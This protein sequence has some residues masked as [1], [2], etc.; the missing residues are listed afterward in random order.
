MRLLDTK[1]LRLKEF[2]GNR[3]PQ[4]AILSHTWGDE[5]VLFQ[6][7]K[8][9]LSLT[10]IWK[11]GSKKVRASCRRAALD[12]YKYIWIDTC[13]I[14]KS[15]SAEISES[16]NSMF[17]W[18]QSASVCY[19][20]LEDVQSLERLTDSR[21]FTRGWTLQ[22]LIAPCD[23]RFYN[24]NWELLGDRYRL[25][26]SQVRVTGIDM[27]ILTYGHL[28]NTLPWE[29]H[30]RPDQRHVKGFCTAC[31]YEVRSVRGLLGEV[32]V[33]QKM[34]W[35]SPRS[36]TR[37]EDLSY[38]LLGIFG[39]S[40]TLI[41]GEGQEK[42]F[43]RLQET[44]LREWDDQTILAW[45]ASGTG[46]PVN[47]VFATSPPQFLLGKYNVRPME[48]QATRVRIEMALGGV[49][50]TTILYPAPFYEFKGKN[51]W[52]AI[53]DCVMGSDL[54]SR[55][56]L[57]LQELPGSERTFRRCGICIVEP[58][59]CIRAI[60]YFRR[61]RNYSYGFKGTEYYI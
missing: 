49:Y 40:M 44:I 23:V 38:C 46:G 2:V 10:W 37:A 12:G 7:I 27:S 31:E 61:G 59:N 4:Y 21:W 28:V 50:L 22:E 13:C 9:H 25:L 48:L 34:I 32:S 5:E 11:H 47:Q 53:L 39:V 36:T 18:Y 60:H 1:Y 16:I 3:I 26:K 56:A 30:T 57:L 20:F 45:C 52:I 43:R 51:L 6:D 29:A 33:S 24:K 54:R 17:A 8:G 15:S 19:A 14:D 42:A 55:P 58:P 41:Y 35:A